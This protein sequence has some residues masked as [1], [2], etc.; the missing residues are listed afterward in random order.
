[1]LIYATI[2]PHCKSHY[3]CVCLCHYG[4]LMVILT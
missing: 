4:V 2:E 1:M 3:F